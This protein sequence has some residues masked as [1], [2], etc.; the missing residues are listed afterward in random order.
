MTT[1][2]LGNDT[3]DRTAEDTAQ[4]RRAA[5]PVSSCRKMRSSC[6]RLATNVASRTAS[7]TF[8]FR[9]LLEPGVPPM[10]VV[11]ASDPT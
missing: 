1:F 6:T 10:A 8:F 9:F 2:Q 4:V 11:S 5:A 7:A 3:G